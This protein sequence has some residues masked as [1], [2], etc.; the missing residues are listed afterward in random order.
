ML[1]KYASRLLL[2]AL[3]TIV[4][5]IFFSP[6]SFLWEGNFNY[7]ITQVLSLFWAGD[8]L[9]TR[10][11]LLRLDALWFLVALFWAKY[12]FQGVGFLVNKSF[13]RYQD[14]ILL[15]VSFTI[16]SGA[17][18]LH[19]FI[20]FVPWEVMKGLSAVW[21]LAIGWYSKRHPLPVYVWIAFV[22]C[23]LF[24]LKI[25]SLDMST[26]TYKTYPLEAFGAVG[27]TW[28]VY[29]LSKLIQNH[30][31]FTNKLL[32]WF[33]MNSLLIL[34]VNTLDRRSFLVRAIKGIL[35]IH[36]SGVLYNTIIHYSIGL[37]FV[38][39]LIYIPCTNRLFGAARWRDLR[40][41]L[42]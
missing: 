10:F 19:K 29:L 13:T 34:C 7:T 36:P 42:E 12:F 39:A 38:I 32:R 15:V 28:L 23:W 27:A 11:G 16:S 40:Y 8:A 6:L 31:S 41:S 22:I 37:A 1:K 25:G 30:T 2:P 35:N 3:V 26:Y 21:F 18:L 20:P 33:G 5:I 9:P 14:E 4:C 24:A 17:I